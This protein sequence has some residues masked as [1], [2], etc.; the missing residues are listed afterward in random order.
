MF[1]VGVGCCPVPPLGETLI[2]RS[3]IEIAISHCP[4]KNVI[5]PA[6]MYQ[7]RTFCPALYYYYMWKILQV[8][9]DL[10]YHIAHYKS[11]IQLLYTCIQGT[12][13]EYTCCR[14]LPLFTFTLN[15]GQYDSWQFVFCKIHIC[16]K[17]FCFVLSRFWERERKFLCLGEWKSL[18]RV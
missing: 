11:I 2:N 4:I 8:K 7:S 15:A 1:H 10:A 9:T 5:Y 18:S 14:Q 16:C 17:L 13:R 12:I 6:L 3:G